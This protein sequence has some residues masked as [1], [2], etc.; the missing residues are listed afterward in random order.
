MESI[1]LDSLRKEHYACVYSITFGDGKRYVGKTSDIGGRIDLYERNL[2]DEDKKSKVVEALRES[3]GLGSVR[4]DVLVRVS[5]MCRSDMEVCLSVLEIKYIKEYDCIYPRGYNVSYGGEVF[6]IP[7]EYFAVDSAHIEGFYGSCKV[8]LVYDGDGNFVSEYPSVAR[9]AYE[10]GIKE[11]DVSSHLHSMKSYNGYYFREKRF[12]VIPQKIDVP[13]VVERVR[14]RDV[15]EERHIVRERVHNRNIA[16]IVYDVNGDFVG[17]FESR[18]KASHLLIGKGM[19]AL[20]WGEY[21]RGYVFY[22]KENDDYPKK[23]EAY[24]EF[25]GKQ[26]GET[27]RPADSLEVLPML[28]DSSEY[29]AYKPHKSLKVQTAVNQFTMDGVFV[30]QYGSI[31]DAANVTGFR[32]SGIYACVTEKTKFASGYVWQF[33]E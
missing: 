16:C 20:P 15:V 5:G 17:E 1:D 28:K 26:T 33:A 14:Y 2:S 11:K 32:Y 22:R 4:F 29:K 13:K 9:C 8:V 19:K 7:L 30:A 6:N 21:H 3:G 23:I 24:N 25:E 18:S 12:N 27:Y 31:R 10:R